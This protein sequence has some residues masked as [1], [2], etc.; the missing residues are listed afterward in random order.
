MK[1]PHIFFIFP[2]FEIF[3]GAFAPLAP[4][5]TALDHKVGIVRLFKS[6]KGRDWGRVPPPPLTILT[7]EI[8]AESC[9]PTGKRKARKWTIEKKRRKIVI[10]KYWRWKIENGM[11]KKYENKQR[12]FFFFCNLLFG[13]QNGNFA[14]P[15]PIKL[16]SVLTSHLSDTHWACWTNLNCVQFYTCFSI[17]ITM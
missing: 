11:G 4:H 14:P 6:A 12:T 15:P 10:L 16:S 3:R 1:I 2:F 13:E 17:S 9:W 7:W 5:G 8:F